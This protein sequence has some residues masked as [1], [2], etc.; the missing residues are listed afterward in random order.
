MTIDYNIYNLH[1]TDPILHDED[2]WNGL[3]KTYGEMW[4]GE[5]YTIEKHTAAEL[6]FTFDG[7]VYYLPQWY[8][9]RSDREIEL[10]KQIIID[11]LLAEAANATPA[12]DKY[13]KEIENQEEMEA[14]I[15]KQLK[16][17]GYTKKQIEQI[18]ADYYSGRTLDSAIQK[19]IGC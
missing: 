9:F 5:G 17:E 14:Y 16:E 8:K 1:Y 2:C 7:Q 4:E 13:D 6:G 3:Y 18:L 19:A 12:K 15:S 10:A 11:D